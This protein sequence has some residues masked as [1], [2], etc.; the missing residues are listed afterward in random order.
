MNAGN[1]YH[2]GQQGPAKKFHTPL[3][4]ILIALI[5]PLYSKPRIICHARN[6]FYSEVWFNQPFGPAIGRTVHTPP[7]SGVKLYPVVNYVYALAPRRLIIAWQ[8]KIYGIK[9]DYLNNRQKIDLP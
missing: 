5:S 4:Q 8:R 7:Y 2:K 3:Y 1:K 9:K 6:S